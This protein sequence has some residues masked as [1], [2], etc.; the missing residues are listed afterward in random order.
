MI[1]EPLFLKQFKLAVI[2]FSDYQIY[3]IYAILTS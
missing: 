1:V 2:L 3:A